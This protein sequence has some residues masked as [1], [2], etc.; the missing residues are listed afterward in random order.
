MSDCV[1]GGVWDDGSMGEEQG[2][3][4][5]A[6]S[7]AERRLGS[8]DRVVALS[9]GV[10]AIIITILVLEIAVPEDLSDRSLV[11]ALDDLRP[12]LVVWVISFLLTGM[13]WVAHRDLFARVRVVNRDVVWLNLLFLLPV[14]LI[15][16]AASVLGKYPDE[17]VALHLYGVVLIAATLMRFMLYWYVVKRP[18]LLGSDVSTDRAGLGLAITAAPIALYVVAI[19][20][21]G[22]STTLSTVLYFSVPILY[23]ILVTVLREHPNTRSEA[24]EIHVSPQISGRGRRPRHGTDRFTPSTT[25]PLGHRVR[26]GPGCT[27]RRFTRTSPSVSL[28]GGRRPV[29]CRRTPPRSETVV[30]QPAEV[31]EHVGAP[32]AIVSAA[33]SLCQVQIRAVMSAHSCRKAAVAA[34]VGAKSATEVLDAHLLDDTGIRDCGRQE[35]RD[36]S[37]QVSDEVALEAP[38]AIDHRREWQHD[39]WKWVVGE[40]FVELVEGAF[41]QSGGDGRHDECVGGVEDA[42][43]GECDPWGAVEDRDVVAVADWFEERG[44]ASCR[45]FGVVEFEVEVAQGEVSGHD[46]NRRVV[47]G[48]SVRGERS[49]VADE[50]FGSAFDDGLDADE[51]GGGALW[52]EV[53]QHY[54]TASRG[55]FVGE[56]QP[57][58]VVVFPTPPLML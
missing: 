54:S 1:A 43:A 57:P 14:S 51:A 29:D 35:A 2:A 5:A 48:V 27:W 37:R 50:P 53:P 10:F 28:H 19:A 40:E 12:T 45:V 16:F 8:P 18:A 33:R 44:E 23:F 32:G 46:M 56:V 24:D 15:P 47:H 38:A 22:V 49:G 3:S 31:G 21:A 6:T 42:F 13:F 55:C 4:G 9:D 36:V 26:R 58:A 39:R 11:Q 52:V 41:G 17:P 20:L 25:S 30:R 7:G 34:S